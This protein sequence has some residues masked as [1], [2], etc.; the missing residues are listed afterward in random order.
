MSPF[1]QCLTLRLACRQLPIID[2]IGF[3]LEEGLDETLTLQHLRV[4]GQLWKTLG[5]CDEAPRA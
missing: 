5:P 4:H 1:C 3:V 2:L